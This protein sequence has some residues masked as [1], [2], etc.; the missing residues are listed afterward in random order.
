MKEIQSAIALHVGAGPATG[1]ALAK[2]FVRGGH[3]VVATR[4]MNSKLRIW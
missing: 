1:G 4:V 3:I 2:W